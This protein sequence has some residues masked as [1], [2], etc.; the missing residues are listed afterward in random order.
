MRGTGIGRLDLTKVMPKDGFAKGYTEGYLRSPETRRHL[1]LQ[2]I[3]PAETEEQRKEGLR[4]RIGR[5]RA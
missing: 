4:A 1:E 2:E 3:A 5:G